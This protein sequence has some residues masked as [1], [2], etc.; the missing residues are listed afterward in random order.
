MNRNTKRIDALIKLGIHLENY[1]VENPEFSELQI[2]VEKAMQSNGWFTQQAI[3]TVFKS[4]A[5][6]L[7]KNA[8]QKATRHFF[9][10]KPGGRTGSPARSSGSSQ[11]GR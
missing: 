5:F 7:K 11:G 4:W 1:T 6:A 2:C 8:I 10:Q 3:E 9:G